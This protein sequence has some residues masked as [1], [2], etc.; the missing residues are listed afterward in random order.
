MLRSA[1]YSSSC[2]TRSASGNALAGHR[3][4]R[5]R[6]QVDRRHRGGGV[7][8]AH[9]GLGELIDR[10]PDPGAR[11][12]VRD[13][14][15]APAAVVPV[16]H[17]VQCDR[18]AQVHV[19]PAEA[20][21]QHAPGPEQAEHALLLL[22]LPGELADVGAPLDQPLVPEIDR[23][24]HHRPLGLAQEAAHGHR[25]HAGL[26]LQQTPGAAAAPFDEILERMSAPHDGRQVLHQD[27]GV[28][29]MAAEAAT[30]EER[31]TLAQQ[32]PDQRQVQVH[33]RGGVRYGIALRVDG[34][35]EQQVIHVTAVAGNVDELVP[36]SDALERL[37]VTELDAVVQPVPQPRQRVLHE[38]HEG[39]GVVGGDLERQGART[40]HRLVAAQPLGAHLLRHRGTHRAGAQDL[41]DDGAPVREVRAYAHRAPA[42]VQRAQAARHAPPAQRDAQ[43]RPEQLPQ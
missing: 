40:Q 29:G 27:H 32:A 17:G 23:D 36:F 37:D 42:R 43:V 18:L 21:A 35:A 12:L 11:L 34:I 24:E 19:H 33:P 5:E 16:E 15:A 1:R 22:G 30:D 41:I 38:A 2:R 14:L 13:A 10:A 7:D 20:L 8:V 28:E 25:Q 4:E 39:V 3:Q 6:D 31:P 9:D 26:R